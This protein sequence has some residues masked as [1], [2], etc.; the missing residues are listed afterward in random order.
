MSRKIEVKIQVAD[1]GFYVESRR[2]TLSPELIFNERL[3][4]KDKME[5]FDW[6]NG[7]LGDPILAIYETQRRENEQDKNRMG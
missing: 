5:L 6:L 3:V 2:E 7:E 4:F 1:N